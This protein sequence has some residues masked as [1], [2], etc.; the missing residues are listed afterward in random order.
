M[1]TG[2]RGIEPPGLGV[3]LETSAPSF[4]EQV[5]LRC[6]KRWGN[7]PPKESSRKPQSI[8]WMEFHFCAIEHPAGAVREA[9]SASRP[10]EQYGRHQLHAHLART[11]KDIRFRPSILPQGSLL[12]PEAGREAMRNLPTEFLRK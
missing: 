7:R 1:L 12:N 8:C 2:P 5:K 6:L 11:P 4:R 9:H 10:A 3:P